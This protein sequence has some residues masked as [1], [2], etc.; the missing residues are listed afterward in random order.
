MRTMVRRSSTFGFVPVIVV[1]QA[2]CLL[3]R[4]TPWLGEWAWTVDWAAG[5]TVLTAPLLAGCAAFEVLRWRAVPTV[6]LLRQTPRGPFA[7]VVCATSVW[8]IGATVHVAATVAVLV[9]TIAAGARPD[10]SAAFA[11]V[12]PIAVLAAAAAIGA[13]VATVWRSLLCVPLAAALVFGVTAFPADLMLPDVF[14]VGGTTGSLVGLTWDVRQQAVTLAVLGAVTLFAIVLTQARDTIRSGPRSRAAVAASF[15]VLVASVVVADLAPSSRLIASDAPIRYDCER[16]ATASVCL[17]S[18]TSRQLHWLAGQIFEQSEPLAAIGVRLPRR[19]Q[20]LVPYR[21]LP[22]G[23]APILLE[24]DTINARR[25]D[26]RRIPDML[27]RPALCEADT[28]EVPPPDEVFVARSAIA[29]WLSIQ[30]G[31]AD[32]GDYRGEVFDRWLDRDR[33]EQESWIKTTYA[34]LAACRY[35]EIGLPDTVVLP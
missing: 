35:G 12:L 17:A 25:G 28:A 26:V 22:E 34:Q 9:A 27:V 2:F 33:A 1:V 3:Q 20:Q 11:L 21:H 18:Q 7:G 4:G 24:S 6:S 32:A 19:H 5:V 15:V 16:S 13:A 29:A 8:V 10:L 31:L 14:K 30:N 23:V